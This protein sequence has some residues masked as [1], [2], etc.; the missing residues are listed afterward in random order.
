MF[1][2]GFFL[3]SLAVIIGC[4]VVFQVVDFFI[5]RAKGDHTEE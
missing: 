4:L 2:W 5:T 3:E 1:F